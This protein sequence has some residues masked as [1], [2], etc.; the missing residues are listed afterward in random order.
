MNCILNLITSSIMLIA[1]IGNGL[2]SAGFSYQP[3][4][5]L[6]LSNCKKK[7]KKK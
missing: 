6:K 7:R 2:Y 1:N 4:K 3:Q 5:P